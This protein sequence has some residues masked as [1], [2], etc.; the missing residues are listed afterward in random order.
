MMEHPLSRTEALIGEEALK[1]LRH[2]S[3]TVLGIGGVGSYAVE[4]LARCGIGHLCLVDADKI[5]VTNI[6][7]QIHATP[8][9]VGQIKVE[10]MAARIREIDPSICVTA[11]RVRITAEN[12]K[13]LLSPAAHYV[14]DA[15]DTISVK[16]AAAEYCW[17]NDI[18]LISC[19]GAGNKMDPAAFTVADLFQTRQCPVAKVLRRELKKRGV[20]SL[21]VVYSPEV[22]AP[23]QAACDADAGSQEETALQK[24]CVPAS[25]A[26]VPSVA[27]LILAGEAVRD[28]IGFVRKQHL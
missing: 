23:V 20:P 9:T 18:P 21:K 28:L 6:N 4:A 1:Q 10:A 5:S 25:I 22:P 15:V 11:H 27:G 13:E 24:R 12:L 17:R 2:S 19:M 8:A 14:I 3:V 26:F 7:R 16:I